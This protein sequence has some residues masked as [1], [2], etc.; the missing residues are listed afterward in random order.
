MSYTEI[1]E[2]LDL[3]RSKVSTVCKEPKIPEKRN[4]H[5]EIRAFDTP[6]KERLIT[7]VESSADARRMSWSELIQHQGLNCSS[8]TLQRYLH[9]AGFRRCL[10]VP[11]PWLTEIKNRI[12]L[13]G[14][15][16]IRIG[17]L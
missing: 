11:K 8:R 9:D 15:S 17:T 6:A 16:S 12:V 1:R 10:A 2:A 5:P 4:K 7:F 14:L 3:P 13:T